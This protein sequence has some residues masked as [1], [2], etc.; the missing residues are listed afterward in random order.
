ML[1]MHIIVCI[2]G[3]GA[4]G[5][6]VRAAGRVAEMS[7]CI[8]FRSMGA[9]VVVL[10]KCSNGLDVQLVNGR[11][12]FREPQSKPLFDTHMQ[13]RS[14]YPAQKWG[15]F[16]LQGSER[17]VLPLMNVFSRNWPRSQLQG[18]SS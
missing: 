12:P 15:Q 8:V 3:S 6:G 4:I 10:S 18:N 13:G 17:S 9:V 14:C 1:L 2:W 16:I 7:V 5:L 11:C